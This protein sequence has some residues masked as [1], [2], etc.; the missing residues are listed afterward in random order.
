MLAERGYDWP[1]EDAEDL[2]DLRDYFPII[3]RMQTWMHHVSRYDGW[4]ENDLLQETPEAIL[5]RRKWIRK[6][7]ESLFQVL[8]SWEGWLNYK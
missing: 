1:E 3:K 5:A 4:S 2:S 8:S 7:A 6:V